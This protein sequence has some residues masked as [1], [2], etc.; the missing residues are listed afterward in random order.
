MGGRRQAWHC[1]APHSR[2]H[3][4]CPDGEPGSGMYTSGHTD[5]VRTLRH[6]IRIE[7]HTQETNS[8]M[9]WTGSAQRARHVPQHLLPPKVRGSL[10][11][12]GDWHV[13]GE[14]KVH[15]RVIMSTPKMTMMTR[16]EIRTELGW[17]DSM[18]HSLLQLPDSTNARR[19]K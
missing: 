2:R 11:P 14:E 15:A 6:E 4:G 16:A 9:Q 3:I 18:I 8:K 17:T 19:C 1:A 7:G 13:E 5:T 10:A 12:G